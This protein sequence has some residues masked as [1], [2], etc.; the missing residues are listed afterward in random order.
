MCCTPTLHLARRRFGQKRRL[1]PVDSACNG[2]G[3]SLRCSCYTAA[4]VDPAA[5]L[6]LPR[7]NMT[8]LWSVQTSSWDSSTRS[9]SERFQTLSLSER[10]QKVLNCCSCYIP[11]GRRNCA[12]PS[13]AAV[14]TRSPTEPPRVGIRRIV[15]K[16]VDVSSGESVFDLTCS[17][18]G[19]MAIC[20]RDSP[21]R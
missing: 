5:G 3:D 17:D 21:G 7:G 15:I 4:D 6:L 2:A 14:P 16:T 11:E 19:L 20:I 9:V 13:S 8:G 12:V 1:Q 18:G 10:F